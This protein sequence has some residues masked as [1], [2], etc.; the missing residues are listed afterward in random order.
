MARWVIRCH[1]FAENE[2]KHQNSP[3][4]GLLYC[5]LESGER[6]WQLDKYLGQKWSVDSLY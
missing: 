1:L 4:T 2:L 6:A 5:T 3:L